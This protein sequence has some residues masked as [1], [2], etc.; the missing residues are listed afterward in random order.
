MSSVTPLS[1]ELGPPRAWRAVIAVACVA[2]IA[3]CG[4]VVASAGPLVLL[5]AACI[6]VAGIAW[7]GAG[8]WQGVRL[9]FDAGGGLELRQP[10]GSVRQVELDHGIHLGALL[11]IVVRRRDGRRDD[12][13]VWRDQVDADAWRRLK[14]RVDRRHG[15]RQNTDS[16]G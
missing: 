6:G 8:R 2:A 9:V 7:R 4:F 14:V 16:A 3:G 15:S 11:V 13:V 1:V 10:D 5:A 12:V